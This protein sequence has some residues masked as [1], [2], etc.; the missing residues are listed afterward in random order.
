[1][2]RCIIIVA[3]NTGSVRETLD[4]RDDD[5][6]I[7]ADGG[8]DLAAADGIVPDLLIGD[9]DSLSAQSPISGE[10]IRVPSEK[11]DTDL[12][13]C[14]DHALKMEFDEYIIIGGIGGRLDHTLGNIQALSY[15]CDHIQ[16][17][18]LMDPNNTLIM[19]TG[20]QTTL[21]KNP[22]K[23]YFSVFSFTER[24]TGV[25]I[26]GAKYPLNNAEI[27]S[28]QTL[29]VSNEFTGNSVK[30]SASRGKLLIVH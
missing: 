2:G 1:M 13:I 9:F 8:Y 19:L 25:Y 20:T 23:Q 18:T 24:C 22:A 30:I 7:C 29:G 16:K 4:I 5:Y 15:A 21:T 17:I 14:L 27:R 26:T 28:N 10:I 11:D 6:I 12:T 3:Y